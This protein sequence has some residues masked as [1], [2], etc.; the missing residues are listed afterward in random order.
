MNNE[1][2]QRLVADVEETLNHTRWG[3]NISPRAFRTLYAGH[4]EHARLIIQATDPV[5]EESRFKALLA[6]V[7]SLVADF[8]HP[9]TDRVGTGMTSVIGD[10]I[11]YPSGGQF[12]PTVE[13]LCRNLLRTAA[14]VGSPKA[15]RGLVDWFSGRPYVYHCRASVVGLTF[16]EAISTQGLHVSQLPRSVTELQEAISTAWLRFSNDDDLLGKVMLSF[17]VA[18]TPPLYRPTGDETPFDRPVARVPAFQGGWT[19]LCFALSLVTNHYV[20]WKYSW[21]D[22]GALYLLARETGSGYSINEGVPFVCPE[23]SLTKNTLEESLQLCSRMKQVWNQELGI[24]VQRWHRSLRPGALADRFIDLRIA[25]ESLYLSRGGGLKFR[26]A[27]CG[28]WHLGRDEKERRQYYDLLTRAYGVASG[29]IHTGRIN[30]PADRE[31]ETLLSSAQDAC[32][33]GLM[34]WIKEGR[35]PGGNT[36]ELV[37]GGAE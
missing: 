15:G 1:L 5:V 16:E 9:E 6:A 26:L 17:D 32:R 25:L 31:T 20:S 18:A 34:K 37:L 8:T 35:R 22:H 19:D 14:V 33:K 28:A 36:L 30:S 24:A 10:A 3:D 7:R 21:T 23:A 11:F 12:E 4:N 27:L 13:D 2:Q 29:A